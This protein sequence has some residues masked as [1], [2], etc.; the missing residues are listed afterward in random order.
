MTRTATRPLATTLI[1]AAVAASLAIAGAPARL[2]TPAW[3]A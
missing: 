3:P 1:A 2:L